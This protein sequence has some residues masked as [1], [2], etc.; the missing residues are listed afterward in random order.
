MLVAL[1]IRVHL[2]VTQLAIDVLDGTLPD[3]HVAHHVTAR[4]VLQHFDQRT[5]HDERCRALIDLQQHALLRLANGVAH[6]QATE[7]ISIDR[8]GFAREDLS[9]QTEKLSKN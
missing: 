2:D 6:S 1:V 5:G 4:N 3:R 8:E 7:Q 9:V